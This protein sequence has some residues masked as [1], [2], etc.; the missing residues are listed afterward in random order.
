MRPA[1]LLE[2]G[3]GFE[4]R[5]GFRFAFGLGLGLGRGSGSGLGLDPPSQLVV[6]QDRLLEP[7]G[8]CHGACDL[9][10]VRVGYG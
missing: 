2:L 4:F 10:G 7:T 3:L 9:V 1:N 8:E 6:A 5:L